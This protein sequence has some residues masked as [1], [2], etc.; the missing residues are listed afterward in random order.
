MGISG[1][2]ENRKLGSWE[3]KTELFC[4][5]LHGIKHC[6]NAFALLIVIGELFFVYL[7]ACN[8]TRLNY[9]F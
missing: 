3:L 6:Y 4:I 2:S 5:F 8:T 7:T 1:D 9:S